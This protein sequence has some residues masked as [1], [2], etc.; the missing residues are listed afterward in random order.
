MAR[1]LR[2]QAAG[3]IYHV[4]ARGN[5]RAD[6]FRSAADYEL[7]LALFARVCERFDWDVFGYCLMP[8]HVHLVIRT[9][10]ANIAAGMQRLHGMYAQFFNWRYG[11]DGHL[12]GG[13]YKTKLIRTEAHAFET[14]RY[15]VLNPVRANLCAHPGKWRWSSYRAAAGLSPKPR[16]LDLDWLLEQFGLADKRHQVASTLS[17]R[18]S[19]TRS[20]WTSH[21]HTAPATRSAVR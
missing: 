8:N 6:I 9:R 1:P 18:R 15:V 14:A 13:R 7:Y 11:L 3:A 20:S 21:G 2:V 19:P 12:F 4:T 10:E 17:G 5:R 16:F